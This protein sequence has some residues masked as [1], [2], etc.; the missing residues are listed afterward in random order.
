MP[1]IQSVIQKSRSLHAT[2][3]TAGAAPAADTASNVNILMFGHS[4]G[5]GLGAHSRL[6][7]RACR[8]PAQPRTFRAGIGY[9]S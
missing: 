9:S 6:R 7:Q 8:R 1:V 5:K 2:Y 3:P 4:A